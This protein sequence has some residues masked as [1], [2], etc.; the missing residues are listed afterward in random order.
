V[1]I[2]AKDAVVTIKLVK[3]PG[4]PYDWHHE[5]FLNGERITHGLTELDVFG[6]LLDMILTS[7]ITDHRPRFRDQGRE[8]P[9]HT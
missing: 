6:E 2:S 7:Y 3:E 1:K 5:V 8:I 9:K 4:L